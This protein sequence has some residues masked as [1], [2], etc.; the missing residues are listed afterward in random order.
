MLRIPMD[1]YLI[2][3]IGHFKGECDSYQGLPRWLYW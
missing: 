1:Y 3:I 2:T